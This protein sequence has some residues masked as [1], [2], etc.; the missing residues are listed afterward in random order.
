VICCTFFHLGPSY[1]HCCH[2][3]TFATASGGQSQL[4]SPTTNLKSLDFK[5]QIW[6]GKS[7]R[8]KSNQITNPFKVYKSLLL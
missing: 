7:Q 5:S 4:K 3:L 2:A 1:I 8:P 6:E